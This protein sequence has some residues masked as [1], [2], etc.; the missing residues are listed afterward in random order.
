MCFTFSGTYGLVAV[1]N[2]SISK[3]SETETLVTTLAPLLSD[4]SGSGDSD[5]SDEFLDTASTNDTF[6]DCSRFS[7]TVSPNSGNMTTNVH[8]ATNL[9]DIPAK[10]I[11]IVML[12]LALWLYSIALTRKAWYR[13]LKE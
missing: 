1:L 7:G 3:G 4:V 2:A 8:S 13:I 5:S 6:V 11:V 10:E 12:M 9:S